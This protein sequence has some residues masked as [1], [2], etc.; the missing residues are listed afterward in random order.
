[1]NFDFV[2]KNVV[3][4]HCNGSD[5][6]RKLGRSIAILVGYPVPGKWDTHSSINFPVLPAKVASRPAVC[7]VISNPVIQGKPPDCGVPARIQVVLTD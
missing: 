5:V 6:R 7:T 4:S 1:M 3:L 2:F